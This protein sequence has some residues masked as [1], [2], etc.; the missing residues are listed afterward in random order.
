MDDASIS[1]AVWNQSLPQSQTALSLSHP[2]LHCL[3]LPSET[4]GLKAVITLDLDALLLSRKSSLQLWLCNYAKKKKMLMMS[5]VNLI[6][7]KYQT[8]PN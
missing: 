6:M 2:T 1:S 5:N 8:K 7:R 3:P 4:D